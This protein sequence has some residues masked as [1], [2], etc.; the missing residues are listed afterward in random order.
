MI[1][2]F[3]VA[4]FGQG[5]VGLGWAVIADISPRS[6]MG[7]TGGMFSLAANLGGIVTPSVVEVIISATGSFAWALAFIGVVTAIRS[8]AYLFILSDVFRTELDP[9]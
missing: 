4:F 8:L 2:V 1:S 3:S 6:L 9:G 5:L 7:V